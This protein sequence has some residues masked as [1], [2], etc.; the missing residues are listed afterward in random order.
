[1]KIALFGGTFDP[2]HVGHLQIAK[3][4]IGELC[5]DEVWFIPAANPP[6][7][8]KCMF[9]FNQRIMFLKEATKNN[10]KFSVWEKDFRE[11][12]KSYTIYLINELKE[13]YSQ[14]HFS[15]VIGAD[16]VKKLK[17]WKD[18]KKLLELIEFIAID[19]DSYDREE[20]RSLDYYDKLK[21]IDMPLINIS[22]SEIRNKILNN[23]DIS[24][25]VPYKIDESIISKI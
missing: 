23:D 2:V 6:H 8:E 12:D 10:S 11:S 1:M 3:T 19:R 25:Y 9:S 22:S 24:Q 17:F 18:Y 21:F 20:Y 7:K 13:I 5:M 14:Y 15:F 16:N 4:I